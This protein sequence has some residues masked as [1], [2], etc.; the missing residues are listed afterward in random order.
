MASNPEEKSSVEMQLDS[1]NVLVSNIDTLEESPQ[2][3]PSD[4][5]TGNSIPWAESHTEP[6]I[7][8]I[9]SCSKRFVCEEKKFIIKSLKRQVRRWRSRCMSLR[10]KVCIC[11]M[12]LYGVL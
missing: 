5:H 6:V 7:E 10:K 3:L 8:A 1:D 2:K 11:N 9:P 4:S 12:D